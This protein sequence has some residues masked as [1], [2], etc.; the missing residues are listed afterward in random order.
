VYT[1]TAPNSTASFAR[2]RASLAEAMASEQV[3]GRASPAM[4]ADSAAAG[5]DP[6]LLVAAL[7][8]IDARRVAIEWL[9]DADLLCAC[10]A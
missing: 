7:E 4:P 1:A 10:L 8:E 6:V 5:Y 3:T 9:L 2:Q